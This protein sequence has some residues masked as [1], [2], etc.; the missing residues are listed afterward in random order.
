MR[1]VDLNHTAQMSCNDSFSL[2]ALAISDA[3]LVGGGLNGE[4][5][6]LQQAKAL[7]YVRPLVPYPGWSFASDWDNPDLAFQKRRQIW[8]LFN[9]R[10]L[11]V[12]LTFD[13]YDGLRLN[14][15][16][17]NDLSR[18]LFI[19]GCFE[20]NE[21]A[22]LSQLLAPG[23]VFVDVGANEGLYTLFASKRVGSGG[24]VFAFEPSTREFERLE[25]N[26]LLN[27]LPNVK[28]FRVAL[29][30]RNGEADL[31]V[32]GY[33]HEG[34]NTLGDFAYEGVEL[35]RKE[36]VSTRTLD[37][38]V[39]EEGLPRVDVIKI[40][41]EGAECRVIEGA[42]QV[43][44]HFRPVLLFEAV[45][46]ALRKQ[47]ANRD[48]LLALVTSL[49]YKLFTLQ[50]AP[51]GAVVRDEGNLIAIPS[52]SSLVQQFL[53][54]AQ[55]ASEFQSFTEL[56]GSKKAPPYLSLVV[57]ARND[58]HGGNLLGRMQIFV[59]GWMAQ[60]RRHDLPSELVIVEW[61][62][63]PDRPRLREA[64]QWPPD[65]GPCEVRFI[66]VPAEMHSRYIHAQTLP[67][68]QMI[69]KNVGIRRARGRFIL[70]TNIDI[71]FS[72]ELVAFL[73]KRSLDP[74]RMY[75]ID[76]HDAMGDVPSDA[77]L[78]EQLEYCRTHLLRLNSREGTFPLVPI[79]PSLE[80]K[81]RSTHV[82]RKNKLLDLWAKLQGVI[83][84]MAEDSPAVTITLPVPSPLKRAA[85]FYVEWEGFT[86]I[87]RYLLL[88]K[89]PVR[90]KPANIHFLHTNGCGDFTLIAREHWFK[91]RGY[92]EFDLFSMNLDSVFCYTAHYGGACEEVLPEP[93]RIYHIEHAT[94]SGWT[95]EGQAQLFE[96]L[97]AKGIEFVS[98]ADVVGWAQQMRRLNCTMIFN[99]EDWGLR[100]VDLLET[101]PPAGASQ[102]ARAVSK[103]A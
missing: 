85:Q 37:D 96:R 103:Q 13:W 86:G 89:P 25:Q 4:P 77:S 41:A 8:Q 73:A 72:D 33:Q 17:G 45:D 88:R 79:L 48:T 102:S 18:G 91:L 32:A 46:A 75:R 52:E 11:E 28:R 95:P 39:E 47:G 66:E 93:M 42:R 7:A 50:T 51:P 64:L 30:E 19:A 100:N 99:Q 76:R 60:C 14:L 44:N 36:R 6:V 94:G 54:G 20:P 34:Q 70:A 58:D 26:V 62:P 63:P 24:L 98:Y 23:M 43:I 65:L 69:A 56:I 21:F 80:K 78:D 83:D 16:L 84:R 27:E 38:L 31:A 61:N 53:P 67:L 5:D 87:A 49:K 92:P 68:Y 101:A 55:H 1:R 10:R 71:L 22:L 9:E 3:A 74:A 59:N 35:L 82:R 97:A 57:T 15:Y 40:D 90:T 29:A 2:P 12:P 81:N